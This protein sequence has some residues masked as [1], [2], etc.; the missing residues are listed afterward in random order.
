MPQTVYM[1]NMKLE[2]LKLGLKQVLD[3]IDAGNSNMTEEQC[4]E[5]MRLLQDGQPKSK[6]SYYKAAQY[7]NKSRK[8]ID[9]YIQQGWLVPRSE[10]GFH[11][12]FFYKED[13]DKF[14]N[15]HN[16]QLT[17]TRISK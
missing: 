17:S 13:L 10:A 1:N 7:L 8:A 9:Y 14:L 6:L 2:L 5:L 4:D 16:K 15:E 3:D 12:K 11:E